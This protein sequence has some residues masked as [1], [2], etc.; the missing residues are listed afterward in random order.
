MPGLN[1]ESATSVKFSLDTNAEETN[2]KKQ[3]E[4]CYTTLSFWE[5]NWMTEGT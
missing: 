4:C 2:W 3:F 1:L 5:T